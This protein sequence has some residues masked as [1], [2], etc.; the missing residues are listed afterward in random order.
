MDLKIRQAEPTDVESTCVLL[1]DTMAE[2]GVATMGVGNLEMELKALRT[3]FVLKGNRFSYEF[4]KVAAVDGRVS[5]LLLTLRGDKLAQLEAALT[6]GAFK[7]YTP[8][9]MVRMLWRLMVLGRTDEAAR[10][11]YLIS[12]V[13]VSPEYRRRGIA[14]LLLAQAENEAREQGFTKLVLEVEIG[15][16]SAFKAYEKFGFSTVLTIEF[17]RRAKILG[18]PGYYK[19]L[20]GL[21]G[22]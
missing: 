7:I 10:D 8:I 18:C 9:Q 14:T 17:K 11:E 3:W 6:D 13:A 4:C 20:K 1:A 21:D 22:R 5:G 16:S 2:F 15:N 19:M 12:H